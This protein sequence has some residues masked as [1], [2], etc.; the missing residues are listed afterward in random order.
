MDH[1]SF[2]IKPEQSDLIISVLQSKNIRRKNASWKNVNQVCLTIH[3]DKQA[4]NVSDIDYEMNGMASQAILDQYAIL[5]QKM[6]DHMVGLHHANM[7]PLA[8][9][10]YGALTLA[11]SDENFMRIGLM[12]AYLNKTKN[13][14]AIVA[15]IRPLVGDELFQTPTPEAV[16]TKEAQRFKEILSIVDPKVMFNGKHLYQ[17]KLIKEGLMND[18]EHIHPLEDEA[19]SRFRLQ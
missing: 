18:V 9:P 11:L 2:H 6:I 14:L 1:P 4:F 7:S 16:R 17:A 10:H 15:T 8:G 12:A 5:H 3:D 13:F 19:A